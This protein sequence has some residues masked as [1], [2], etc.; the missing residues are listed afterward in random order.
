LDGFQ[1]RVGIEDDRS[2]RDRMRRVFDHDAV[3]ET[4]PSLDGLLGLDARATG[5]R[6]HAFRQSNRIGHGAMPLPCGT[7]SEAIRH[8]GAHEDPCRPASAHRRWRD[9]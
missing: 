5:D 6:G 4:Q 3:D 8:S 7:G 2:A 1:S 9:R